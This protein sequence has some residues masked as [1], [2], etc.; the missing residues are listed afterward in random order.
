MVTP[1]PNG[2]AILAD[3]LEA[4]NIALVAYTQGYRD[5]CQDSGA[6]A[7]MECARNGW[8][9]WLHHCEALNLEGS[10]SPSITGD[11]IPADVSDAVTRLRER[12]VPWRDG[13][14]MKAEIETLIAAAAG[15]AQR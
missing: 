1:K 6:E 11:A 14:Q 5:G 4:A 13:S 3:G 12:L 2:E 15:E 7:D 8:H 9:D 10:A